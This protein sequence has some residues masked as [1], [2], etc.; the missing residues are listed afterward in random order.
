M[1]TRLLVDIETYNSTT[2]AMTKT[3]PGPIT[4]ATNW[5]QTARL[6]RAGSFS[7]SMPATDSMAQY[8]RPKSSARCWH[9]DGYGLTCQGIGRIERVEL[10]ETEQGPMLDVSGTDLLGELSDRI[11]TYT[12]I[13]AEIEEHPSYVT[14][15][16]TEAA[17][18]TLKMR[19]NAVGD[20]TTYAALDIDDLASHPFVIGYI[21]TFHKIT[22]KLG[23]TVNDSHTVTFQYSSD[24]TWKSLTVTDGTIGGSGK[25]LEQDGSVTFTPPNDWEPATGEILYKIKINC[26]G[27][28]AAE[29]VDIQDISVTYYGPTVDPFTQIMASA[30]AN[31]SFDA[32]NSGHSTL[33]YRPLSGT[34]LLT[35]TGFENYT[36]GGGNE[37]FTD[38]TN[39]IQGT[40]NVNAD[41]DNEHGGSACVKL[42]TTGAT[43]GET[44]YAGVYQSFAVTGTTEYT[45]TFW[46]QGDGSGHDGQWSITDPD[47]AGIDGSITG[48]IDT[49][50]TA[51]S[52]TQVRRTFVTPATTTEIRINLYSLMEGSVA[53]AL[54]D[55]ISVQ[56]GGGKSIYLTCSNET[57][58]E[59]L[60]RG[61]EVSGENFILSPDVY[62]SPLAREVLWLQ[63]DE[64]DC[65]IRAVSNVDPISV[66]SNTGVAVITD[67]AEIE[68]SSE[69]VSY[70]YPY[71]AGMGGSRVTLANCM[72]APP[73]G[74]VVSTSNNY[75]KRTAAETVLGQVETAKSWSD[76][77]KQADDTTA[78]AQSASNILMIQAVNW[79]E[80]HSCTSLDRLTGDV[81][82]FYELSLA[83]CASRLYP[84][85][86]IRVT[87]HKWVDGTYHAVAIDRD[88]W[89]T[90]ATWRVD[91]NGVQT[92]GLEVAT[93]PRAAINDALATATSIRRIIGIQAH[94]TAAGY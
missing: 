10:R 69:L 91:R 21:Y 94:N 43:G 55:D 19:D 29:Y 66:E 52:W 38:W 32:H 72:A 27:G 50:N 88:L 3:G 8:V 73:T 80:T 41:T 23:T 79:L 83:K 58:L 68:D 16:T 81:P 77:V 60:V 62:D 48:P 15:G 5:Q 71:G 34:E 12:A 26:A 75:V 37:T 82:R 51:A 31:W 33:D 42:T 92:T 67:I 35:E 49:L 30:P 84:G 54:Y 39:G 63:D 90:A 78:A 11:V 57:V 61:S 76:I 87:H 36:S 20:T 28:D 4:T 24:D 25:G 53:Y 6:N 13:R 14:A 64:T 7:F 70:V 56:A 65:G 47:I 9:A 17:D 89:I 22:F 2:G 85:Y 1:T 40:A 93:V 59:M 74:Y 86:Q 18:S 45:I 46:T 44:D